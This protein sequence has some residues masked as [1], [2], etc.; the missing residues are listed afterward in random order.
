M[1]VDPVEEITV[2]DME[3]DDYTWEERYRCTG[4][5]RAAVQRRA[6]LTLLRNIRLLKEWMEE[7]LM[8]SVTKALY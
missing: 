4:R 1:D 7:M 6:A 3:V 8:E 5:G 2:Y